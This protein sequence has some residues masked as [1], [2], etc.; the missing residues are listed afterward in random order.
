MKQTYKTILKVAVVLIIGF[1]VLSKIPFNQN[2]NQ[3]I[4]ANIYEN[5]VVTGE[6]TVVIDGEKTNYL[7]HD[8]EEF[9]G[10]F[11]ILSYE[12]TGRKDMH[13]SIRWNSEENIQKL[14][15]FQNGSFPSMDLI[16][17]LIINDE[18]TQFALMFTDGTVI[19]T[20]DEIHQLYTKHISYY[21][22][23]GTT[24]I[25]AVNKIPKI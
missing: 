12:K 14:T 8:D 2:I 16:S 11:H 13:S 5:G 1:W 17:T 9:Y 4:S 25:K 19:A 23:T 7:F 24:S 22:D 3:E 20:S 6:T 21:P 10:K 18:M 15:Y